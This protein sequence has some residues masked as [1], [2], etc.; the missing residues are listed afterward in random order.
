MPP[1]PPAE[2]ER[3]RREAEA[4][5]PERRAYLLW[6]ADEWNKAGVRPPTRPQAR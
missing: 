1:Y 3:L 2:A 5:N 4:A 6:L